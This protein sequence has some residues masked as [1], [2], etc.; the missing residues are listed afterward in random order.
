MAVKLHR[1]PNVWVKVSG[2]PCWK[3]QRALDDKGVEYEIAK[4]PL[5]RGKRDEMEA[6]TGGR[7]YPA[8][9]FDDG[10][11]YR[12][13]PAEME[14]TIREGRLMEKASRAAAAPSG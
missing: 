14:G 1:C 9:E 8:I 6:H 2:H 11:W 5:L 13:E 3:V 4:G 12:E 10:T 7:L